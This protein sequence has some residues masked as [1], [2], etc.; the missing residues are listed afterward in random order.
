MEE[1]IQ[2]LLSHA[3]LGSRRACEE[4]ILA[5]RVFVNGQVARIGQKADP[6]KDKITVDGKAVNLENEPVYI[7]LYKPRGVISA[8]TSPDPRPTV[9]D[10]VDLPGHLYPVGRLDIESEGLILLTN[11]GELANKLTHPRYGHE[12]EYH[13]L[14]ARRLDEDQLEAWRHGVVLEDGYRTAPARVMVDRTSGKGAWLRVIMREGRKR[15]I[16]ETGSQLGLPIVKIIRVRIGSLEL[17]ELKPREWRHLTRQEV[18]S[19]T[20]SKNDRADMNQRKAQKPAGGGAPRDQQNVHRRTPQTH[21]RGVPSRGN[22]LTP[23]STGQKTAGKKS[24]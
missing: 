9:R 1:R 18:M 22:R 3:G 20:E 12:K 8:T 11:D 6:G 15:Q 10:L 23:K 2:K 17:K 14:V 21:S 16:R 24:K 7:A 19:L 5:G 4:Y 13:V